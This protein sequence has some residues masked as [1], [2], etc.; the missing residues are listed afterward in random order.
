[1]RLLT[2]TARI[3]ASRV[4]TGNLEES[5]WPKLLAAADTLSNLNIYIDDQPAQSPLEIR[6]KARHLA[7]TVGGLDIILVDYM[8]LMQASGSHQS[9]EQEISEISRSLKDLAK[10]LSVPVVAVSQLNRS[11]EGRQNKRPMMSDLRESGAIEQ[12]ADV[13]T[14]VY[15]D[16]VYNPVTPDKGMAEIIIGKQRTGAIGTCRMAFVNKYVRFEDLAYDNEY[17]FEPT[18]TPGADDVSL[19]VETPRPEDVIF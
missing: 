2:S 11:L 12:D 8:Q 19:D 6:A 13:I 5:D 15:R 3:D 18:D 17:Q 16:E 1:M 7:K 4:R 9:R 10:D 14:F